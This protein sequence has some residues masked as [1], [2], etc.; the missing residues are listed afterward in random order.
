MKGSLHVVSLKRPKSTI[1]DDSRGESDGE[2]EAHP[3]ELD[4]SKLLGTTDTS[5]LSKYLDQLANP[6]LM[7]NLEYNALGARRSWML[8]FN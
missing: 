4:M 8:Q 6:F 2:P 3:A 5:N 1:F 7:P